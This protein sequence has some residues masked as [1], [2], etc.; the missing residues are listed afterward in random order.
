VN[1]RA[2][3][4]PTEE[5]TTGTILTAYATGSRPSSSRSPPSLISTAFV[6]QSSLPTS[7]R[8][9]KLTAIQ[10]SYVV[11]AFTLAYAIFEIPTA[12]W[13]DALGS[14]LSF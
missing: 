7:L 8:D 10:M 6:F 5:P 3:Q 2:T 13:A 11:S 1:N 9:L 12:R 14:L 4:H